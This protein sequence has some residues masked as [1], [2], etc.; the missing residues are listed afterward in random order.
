MNFPN[1]VCFDKEEISLRKARLLSIP[2]F[3]LLIVFSTFN[4]LIYLRPS[5]EFYSFDFNSTSYSKNILYLQEKLCDSSYKNNI[6]YVSGNSDTFYD[7]LIC[8][9]NKNCNKTELIYGPRFFI[10]QYYFDMIGTTWP[11]VG[12]ITGA[13]VL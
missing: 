3:V 4:S 2:I 12:G 6:V 13:M 1:T 7:C 9:D 5:L 8:H 10:F 11:V